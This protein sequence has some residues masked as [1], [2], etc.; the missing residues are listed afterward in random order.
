MV[1]C[2]VAVS[3]SFVDEQEH[4]TCQFVV[5]GH[6]NS[7]LTC[8]DV[9]TLLETK[10]PNFSDCPSV[11]VLKGGQESLGTIFQHGNVVL[12]RQSD[13]SVHL[14]GI[15]K[16]M[17]NHNGSGA[18]TEARF[19]CFRRHITAAGIDFGKYWDR[20]LVKN[21]CER[22]HVGNG[23]CDDLVPRFGVDGR[24]SGV[25]SSSPGRTGKGVL[26][27]EDGREASFEFVNEFPFC[28]GQDATVDRFRKTP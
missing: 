22:A 12:V 24:D 26:G 27:P 9:F 18:S 23:T 7:A 21:G 2:L 8:S 13:D 25:Y 4:V 14:T 20:T 17:S 6:N 11:S 19:Q 16:Q 28:T 15:P 1:R 10:A 3:P 5:V